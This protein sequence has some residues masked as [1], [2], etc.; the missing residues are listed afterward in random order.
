MGMR[1]ARP[2]FGVGS[3]KGVSTGVDSQGQ[4]VQAEFRPVKCDDW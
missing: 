4:S 1:R 3:G 2:E